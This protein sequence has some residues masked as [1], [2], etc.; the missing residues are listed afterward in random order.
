MR[1]ELQYKRFL[2]KKQERQLAEL[3]QRVRRTRTELEQVNGSRSLRVGR[4]LT[5]PFR[6]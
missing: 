1:K 4:F 6:R 2:V 3:R 5:A